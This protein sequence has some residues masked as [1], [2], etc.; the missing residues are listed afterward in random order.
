MSLLTDPAASGAARDWNY[1]VQNDRVHRLLYTSE[2]IFRDEMLRIF[3]R[4][5]FF[6]GHE[7]EI[8]EPSSYKTVTVG[9]RPLILTRRD[10]GTIEV[11]FNRC[12]HRGTILCRA[13]SGRGKFLACPYHGWVYDLSGTLVGIPHAAGY[14]ARVGNPAW[15]LGRAARVE[16]CHG[17]IFASLDPDVPSLADHLGH[18]R[19]LLDRFMQR[20][21]IGG[22]RAVHG[23]HR[24]LIKANWKASFDNATDGYHPETSH[25]SILSMTQARY[26]QGMSLSHFNGSPDDGPM[27]QLSLG[28]GHTFGDQFPAM[29]DLWAR[30]RPSPGDAAAVAEMKAALPD[31]DVETMLRD[32]PGPGMNLNIFPNLITVGNQLVMLE[33][34]APDRFAMIWYATAIEGAPDALN[35]IRMRIAEDFPNFGEPDDIDIWEKMQDGLAIPEAEWLDMSCGIETEQV[36]AK[37]G[38]RW[39]KISSDTGMRGYYRHYRSLMAAGEP[40]AEGV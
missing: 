5:W 7:S 12:G 38:I 32:A 3:G 9:R 31:A 6:V 1:L 39:G 10:D 4:T 23:A 34:I 29:G 25:A 28:N 15:N 24:M 16:T 8:A 13:P 18:A 27:Y 22:L 40:A 2:Q 30:V 17:L 21:A 26:G 36:D 37:T 11:L 14:G 19:P 35:R 20:S 33:P